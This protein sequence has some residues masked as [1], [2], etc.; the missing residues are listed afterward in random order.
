L[1]PFEFVVEGVPVSLAQRTEAGQLKKIANE[2]KNKGYTVYIEPY[3]VNLPD[4]LS[5]F[6][7]DLIVKNE[8]ETVVVEV[9]SQAS[10]RNDPNIQR[11]AE[12]IQAQPGW[13]LELV[14][15]STDLEQPPDADP[16][17]ILDEVEKSQKAGYSDATLLL[18]WSAIE[19]GL[20]KIAKA[21]DV[22]L[23][24]K[25]PEYL[26]KELTSLGLLEDDVY[27]VL[28]Q[29]LKIRNAVSHGYQAPENEAVSLDKLLEIAKTL[30]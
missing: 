2:Y 30:I 28:W 3:P 16:K 27:N 1:I 6:Y 29:A 20:R 10:L 5:G 23:E 7:P 22:Q 26:V 17:L 12:V 25:S 9:K 18:L 15:I 11:L 24:N 19:I 14:V 13:R 4:F 21:G 8:S